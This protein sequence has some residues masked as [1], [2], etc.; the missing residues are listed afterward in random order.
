MT[1]NRSEPLPQNQLL[2]QPR[3]GSPLDFPLS[4]ARRNSQR[5][6]ATQAQKAPAP[7]KNVLSIRIV[8][9]HSHFQPAFTIPLLAA[10]KA[11]TALNPA[12]NPSFVHF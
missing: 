2:K 8:T 1:K 4:S 9:V 6:R 11:L 7:L 5:L 12:A 3:V 10:N